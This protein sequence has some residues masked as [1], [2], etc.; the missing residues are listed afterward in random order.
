MDETLQLDQLKTLLP[1]HTGEPVPTKVFAKPFR[2]VF[3]KTED[4]TVTWLEIKTLAGLRKVCAMLADGNLVPVDAY[5][6]LD[7]QLWGHLAE[8]CGFLR[9]EGKSKNDFS[10]GI[11]PAGEAFGE[12]ADDL[13]VLFGGQDKV[14]SG[15]ATIRDSVL[16][17]IEANS[18]YQEDG[19]HTY[20]KEDGVNLTP[21]GEQA[22]ADLVGED[23]SEHELETLVEETEPETEE[24]KD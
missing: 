6:T 1:D 19:D 3:K 18:P 21:E 13:S 20:V 11:Q 15:L 16:R 24:E 9:Y 7:R 4:Q 5:A 8:H 23:P 2:V 14:L 22:L 12:L 17:D 10:A